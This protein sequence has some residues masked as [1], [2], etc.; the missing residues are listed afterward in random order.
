[1]GLN[2]ALGTPYQQVEKTESFTTHFGTDMYLVSAP[3][4]APVVVTLDPNAVQGDRVA[5]QD[6]AGNAGSQAIVV[7]ASEGQT[8]LGLGSSLSLNTD[9]GQVQLTYNEPLSAWI[10][11]QSGGSAPG[12]ALAHVWGDSGAV[13]AISNS[14]FTVLAQVTV[15]PTTTGKVR[16]SGSGVVRNGNPAS[17]NF[18]AGVAFAASP[19]TP[20][21]ATYGGDPGGQLLTGTTGEVPTL[22]FAFSISYEITGLT[23]GTAYNIAIMGTCSDVGGSVAA[24]GVQ[25]DCQEVAS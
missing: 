13:G 1:M 22:G 10:A 2:R 21:G 19:T 23:P 14:A 3:T 17:I 16:V 12:V 20:S 15:T 4:G 24:H 11:A 6:V 9:Y 7:D 8:V 18:E 25:I 5:I